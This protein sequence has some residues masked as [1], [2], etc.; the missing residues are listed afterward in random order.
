VKKEILVISLWSSTVVQ[1]KFMA[2]R[3]SFIVILVSWSGCSNNISNTAG[4]LTKKGMKKFGGVKSAERDTQVSVDVALSVSGNYVPPFLMLPRKNCRDCKKTRW[5][6]NES[7]WF[8]KHNFI[9]YMEHFIIH[10]WVRKDQ[11]VLFLMDSG[12]SHFYMTGTV[13]A[14]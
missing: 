9:L 12:Q 5:Q 13:L 2:N 1:L 6:Q 7:G 3:N 4:I 10:N 8:T 14:K 11:L